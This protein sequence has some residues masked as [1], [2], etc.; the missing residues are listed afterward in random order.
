[1]PVRCVLEDK[2]VLTCSKADY[3]SD[4]GTM[5]PVTELVD[6]DNILENNLNGWE[7]LI[8]LTKREK[9][10]LRY[11]LDGKTNREIAQRLYRTER[12]VEYHR[13]RMMRKLGTHNIVELV[14]RAIA[15]GIV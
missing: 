12:T 9:E 11:V 6:S 5:I 14:K 3:S 13:N 4:D 8:T 10:I 15:L 1:M 2:P 7:T